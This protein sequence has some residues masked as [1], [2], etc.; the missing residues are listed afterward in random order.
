MKKNILIVDDE[1]GVRESLR[2]ILKDKYDLFIYAKSE[3]ALEAV[4]SNRIDVALLDIKMPEMNG[5]ELLQKIKNIDQN[6]QVALVTGYATI[7]TAIEAMR[8]GAFDYI[9]KPFD[10]DK[11]EELVKRG[12]EIRK[13]KIKEKRGARQ[14]ETI[15]ER[16]GISEP[17]S[18]NSEK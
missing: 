15:K 5:I 1:L 10:K 2:M 8:L 13:Q 3:E 16:L 11:L 9:K 14:L 18:N 7:D 6:I 12:I 4:R 17:P